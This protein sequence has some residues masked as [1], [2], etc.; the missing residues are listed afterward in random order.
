[1]KKDNWVFWNEQ[2]V[3]LSET[4]FEPR[5]GRKRSSSV[6]IIQTRNKIGQVIM[7]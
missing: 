6:P 5:L 3:P 7:T 1:M 4:T 2:M